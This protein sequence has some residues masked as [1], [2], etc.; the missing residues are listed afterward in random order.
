MFGDIAQSFIAQT[1]RLVRTLNAGGTANRVVGT[2]DGTSMVMTQVVN[3]MIGAGEIAQVF[4]D[5]ATNGS[6]TTSTSAVD[7]PGATR[8]FTST[9]GKILVLF[10]LCTNGSVASIAQY[11]SINIA[12]SDL[13]EIVNVPNHSAQVVGVTFAQ[14][15][16]AAGSV[17]VKGRWRVSSGTA[18][19]YI[20]YLVTIELKKAS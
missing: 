16:P 4:I 11:T 17:T 6:T 18:T 1:K 12:G 3:A 13:D 20:G 5:T 14:A 8:T 19:V 10:V 2:T 9:G 7:V 15:T